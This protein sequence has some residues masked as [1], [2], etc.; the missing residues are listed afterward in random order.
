MPLNDRLDFSAVLATTIHDIKNSL[1]LLIQSIES[2]ETQARERD[3]NQRQELSRLHYEATRINGTLMQLL[4][5]YRVD[6]DAFPLSNQEVF[7]ADMLNDMIDGNRWWATQQGI[8][9]ELDVAPDLTGYF[10]IELVTLL[11][12]DIVMNAIRYCKERVKL[13]AQWADKQ[14][15]I[16]VNDDGPGYPEETLALAEQNLGASMSAS[17][18]RS[19]LGL[20]LARLIAQSHTNH[21]QAG[22]IILQNQGPL[23]GSEFILRLP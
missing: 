10:D 3:D 8:E 16:R 6:C 18:S 11:L 22:T 19:G 1:C 21:G 17:T 5:F 2:L 9:I 13:S 23:G 4:T 12:N 14:L 20:Y 15:E 7:V